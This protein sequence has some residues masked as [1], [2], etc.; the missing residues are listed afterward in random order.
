MHGDTAHAGA[1]PR[2]LYA[3]V[4]TLNGR[5]AYLQLTEP[6]QAPGPLIPL[7]GLQSFELHGAEPPPTQAGASACPGAGC[8]DCRAT[9]G[10]E[11]DEHQR[12]ILAALDGRALRA[13]QLKAALGRHERRLYDP[14][15]G[16]TELLRLGLVARTPGGRYFCTANAPRTWGDDPPAAQAVVT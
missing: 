5:P 1:P 11:P 4:L 3:Q 8:D 13:K 9:S 6:G 15:R 14:A 12:T 16:I 2:A 7:A 10:W